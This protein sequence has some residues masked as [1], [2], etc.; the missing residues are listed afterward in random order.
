MGGGWHPG[1]RGDCGAPPALAGATRPG[2][3][4]NQFRRESGRERLLL[5]DGRGRARRGAASYS[6]V[7]NLS[8]LEGRGREIRYGGAHCSLRGGVSLE[9]RIAGSGFAKREC[10]RAV[11]RRREVHAATEEDNAQSVE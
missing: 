6:F 5:R 8:L 11:D 1:G 7:G 9:G 10:A 2:D 3:F 4:R